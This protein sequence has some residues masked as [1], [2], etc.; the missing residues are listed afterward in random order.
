MISESKK[1][2]NA[3][4]DKAHMTIVACRVTKEKATA[5]KEACRENGTT[6]NAVLLQRVNEYIEEAR[7]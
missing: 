5:F 6:P 3:K 1:A 4:W 7:E 2:S